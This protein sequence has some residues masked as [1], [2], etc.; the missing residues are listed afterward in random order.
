[1]LITGN[2]VGAG[3]LGLP[4]NTGI[5]GFIP[6][7][8]GMFLFGG[9]MFFSA[10][11]LGRE[12]VDEKR[13]T[14]NLPSLY[15][16]YLGRA[17]K[18]IAILANMLILYGLLIAYIAG[19]TTIITKILGISSYYTEVLLILFAILT[20]LTLAGGNMI[21]KYNIFLMLVLWITFGLI[22]FIGEKHAD[23]GRL[24]HMDWEF[25]PVAIPIIVTS[26]H[27]HNIIPNICKSLNW[28]M[29]TIWKAMLTGMIIGYI[30]NALWIQV[31]VG[32]LPL[33]GGENSLVYAFRHNLPATV[34]MSALFAS[35]AFT[36]LSMLFALLAITT[37]YIANGI[38]LLGFNRDLAENFLHKTNKYLVYIMTFAPPLIISFLFPNIFLKA[39]DIVGGIGIV[40]LFGILPGIIFF[41]KANSFGKKVLAVA[42]IALFSAVL[43]F[44]I[45]EKAGFVKLTPRT[46][47]LK[48]HHIKI[49]AK[50]D[51][52]KNQ[53]ENEGEK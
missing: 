4:V 3:I 27:F 29:S 45:T 34:P 53:K 43:L 47:K 9:A 18:W 2:L 1:L 52:N 49:P 8:V 38:G 23:P 5:D 37:S 11:V 20:S 6:S 32:C 48:S 10:V 28:K 31:G 17:G 50:A 44:Q 26:F 41:L 36:T 7:L 13:E 22:V 30:M 35:R 51:R 33:E 46:A 39:I 25:L 24:K 19:G 42:M 21:R 14:F 40:I 16:K 12:A 15:S